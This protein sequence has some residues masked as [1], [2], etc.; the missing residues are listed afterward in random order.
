[1]AVTNPSIGPLESKR[2]IFARWAPRY[3]AAVVLCAVGFVQIALVYCCDLTPW[4]GGGFGMFSTVDSLDARYVKIYLVAGDRSIPAIPPP[5]L[6]AD[7]L[8]VQALP[9]QAALDRLVAK[10][11]QMDWIDAAS[12]QHRFSPPGGVPPVDLPRAGLPQVPGVAPI[13][14]PAPAGD[15]GPVLLPP[16]LPGAVPPPQHADRR[17]GGSPPDTENLPGSDVR[18]VRA[19]ERGEPVPPGSRTF[20]FHRIR[21]EVWRYGYETGSRELIARKM[22]SVEGTAGPFTERVAPSPATKAAEPER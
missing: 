1:M 10:L 13:D 7:Y 14:V 15:G 9:T 16:G 19:L 18:T 2:A 11:G 3:G 12:A 22:A 5:G 6:G 17:P 4:K 21:L 8:R 20:D